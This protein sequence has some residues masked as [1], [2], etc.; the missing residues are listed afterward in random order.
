MTDTKLLARLK[1]VHAAAED[2]TTS[3]PRFV[4]DQLI[5]LYSA[6]LVYSSCCA[7]TDAV[8]TIP[9]VLSDSR[10]ELL[11][12]LQTDTG[13]TS[14]EATCELA[15]T[16]QLVKRMAVDEL[17]YEKWNKRREKALKDEGVSTRGKGVVTVVGDAA[18]APHSRAFPK[19]MKS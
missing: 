18:G 2:G 3:Y 15:E 19:Y 11:Q 16:L 7:G 8:L 17:D 6:L 1:S 4:Q 10:D 5:K 14:A 9:D 12:A 13:L